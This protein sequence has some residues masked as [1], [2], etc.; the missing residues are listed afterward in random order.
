MSEIGIILST[1]ALLS[2]S[3][4]VQRYDAELSTVA[5]DVRKKL[6]VLGKA[7]RGQDRVV[8]IGQVTQ[9]FDRSK[10]VLRNFQTELL[11]LR[12]H[13]EASL[14]EAV[15]YQCFFVDPCIS[16]SLLTLSLFPLASARTP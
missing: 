14:Y 12:G 9:L 7:N 1:R 6:G 13:P 16:S 15:C 3:D 4:D 10:I 2:M 8:L 11:D 5:A